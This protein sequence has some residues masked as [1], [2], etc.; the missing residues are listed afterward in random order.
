MKRSV[1]R[2]PVRI[3]AHVAFFSYR[4]LAWAAA[5]LALTL[6]GLPVATLPRDAGLLLLIGVIN[7]VATA[8]AQ[9]YVRV[10]RQ[11][12]ATMLLDLVAGAAVLWLSG[13]RSLPFLPYAMAG[14]VLPALLFG[15]RGA[16]LGSLTFLALDYVGIALL[17]PEVRS[18]LGAPGLLARAITPAAFAGAWAALA[19]VLT[20]APAA[21]GGQI[22]QID[23]AGAE[24]S[25]HDDDHTPGQ[26]QTVRLADRARP[27]P[28]ATTPANL[29][30]PGPLVLT[31]AAEQRSDPAHR[32]LYDLTPTPDLTLA[33]AL[34]Q[35]GA[36]A[37]RQGSLEV[38][39]T[40]TGS[41]RPL[42][43]AQHSVLMRAAHE[44]LLNVQQHARAHSALLT[45]SFE[46][47]TVALV[48]QDDGVGLLD[49]T[50]ERPGLH[51]LRAIRYRLAE[52]E[53][54]LAV[55][56]SE[57]GGVTVCATLPLEH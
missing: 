7:V 33:S 44:A 20:R 4:W 46:S 54:Q 47:A 55:F 2:W 13:S 29:V 31:R 43:Q 24:H 25:A 3:S 9:G 30:S 1:D 34:E 18:T 16:L 49:G 48:I 12:P 42:N 14:L 23:L 22:A 17:N 6:P 38:R 11:R 27:Q 45:L 50:Y 37:A 56:E 41:P 39:V 36:S 28:T 35:I 21:A 40:C 53:G 32:L 19:H 57:S 5:A 10:A 15:W 52:L 26:P 51:A 8:L